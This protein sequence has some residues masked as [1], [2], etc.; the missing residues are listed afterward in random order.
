M[1]IRFSGCNILGLRPSESDFSMS[2]LSLKTEKHNCIHME[3]MRFY[4][5]SESTVSCKSSLLAVIMFTTII[6]ISIVV[7]ISVNSL[8]RLLHR[9]VVGDVQMFLKYVLPPLWRYILSIFRL[10]ATGT[11]KMSA[12]CPQ[13]RGATTQE[14]NQRQ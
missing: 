4:S 13:P 2:L 9:M 5:S 12:H 8:L 11:S 3:N 14:Q 10:E 7:L 1:E 6:V